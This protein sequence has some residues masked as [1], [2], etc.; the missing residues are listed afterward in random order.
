MAGYPLA[1]VPRLSASRR[2]G[3]LASGEMLV[4]PVVQRV[5]DRPVLAPGA[6][7]AGGLR[8]AGS[9]QAGGQVGRGDQVA[10]LLL[11]SVA[12]VSRR[13]ARAAGPGVAGGS[14][15]QAEVGDT[16]GVP[17]GLVLRDQQQV[18]RTR[19]G[20]GTRAN[21]AARLS[22]AT[23]GGR[24]ARPTITDA[25]D[26]ITRSFRDSRSVVDDYPGRS[27]FLPVR[28]SYPLADNP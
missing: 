23:C 12:A 1:G 10:H 15:E 22:G 8:Q 28:R 26:S 14:E 27:V 13:S 17:G 9:V 2:S 24:T 6:L 5:L 7:Q 19:R 20:S 21:A 16:Q 4:A 11:P 25:G 18:V 3:G